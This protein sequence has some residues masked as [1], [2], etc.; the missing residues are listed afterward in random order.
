MTDLLDDKNN[1]VILEEL[2]S[3]N[4]VSVNYSHLSRYLEKHRHTMIRR[5]QRI[6]DCGLLKPPSVPFLGLAKVYPLL[7]IL[8]I[9]VPDDERFIQWIKQD[10]Y[11]LAAFKTRHLEHNTILL[12]YHKNISSYLRWRESLPATMTAEYKI[13]E[14]L[15]RFA[16]M[17]SYYANDLMVK[18]EPSSGMA[19]VLKEFEDHGNIGIRGCILNS[20]DLEVA[21]CLTNGIG[22]KINQTLLCEK[23]GLHRK[24]VQNRISAL[25]KAGYIRIPVLFKTLQGKYNAFVFSNH[26]RIEDHL[27]WDEE[28]RIRFSGCFGH[29]SIT[30]LTP[31]MTISFDWQIVSLLYIRN[32]M[33]IHRGREL[34]KALQPKK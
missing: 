15:T 28:Y 25:I 29:A 23:T 17:T 22:L 18:Y 27:R 16:S 2:V 24:T 6:F 7:V 20:A 31:M 13:P 12:I 34:R 21:Q 10:P 26:Y 1:L 30:Y 5:V 4:A 32:R 9:E 33:G 19:L 8:H 11:I 14:H 3:G